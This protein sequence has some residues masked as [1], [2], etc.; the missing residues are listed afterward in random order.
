MIDIRVDFESTFHGRDI[1]GNL[2]WP[3]APARLFAALVAGCHGQLLGEAATRSMRQALCSLES[4]P[5]PTVFSAPVSLPRVIAHQAYGSSR[6][7]ALKAIN[8][9]EFKQTSG[10]P[11]FALPNPV[12]ATSL[13]YR[14]ECPTSLFGELD[15][16]AEGV[17][18]FGTS[19]DGCAIRV[20]ATPPHD[21]IPAH[22]QRWVPS[23]DPAGS[24]RSWFPGLLH[25][26]DV[27]F[28]GLSSGAGVDLPTPHGQR[29]RY[30]KS[31]RLDA[32]VLEWVPLTFETKSPPSEAIHE[33]MEAM[34]S[35][36]KGAI[37]PL[38]QG[39]SEYGRGQWLG[40]AVRDLDDVHRLLALPQY[41]LTYDA[42]DQRVW[43][44]PSRYEGP[45]QRWRTVT[46][47]YGPVH[48]EAATA[49]ANVIC[50]EQSARLL[51]LERTKLGTRGC[52]RSTMRAHPKGF[53]PYTVVVETPETLTRPDFP[54]TD[55]VWV[56]QATLSSC[57]ASREHGTA[58]TLPEAEK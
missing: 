47:W 10:K 12:R 40:V 39:D 22:W 58:L 9:T 55:T 46:P 51:Q 49:W 13:I 52:A 7:R 41:G 2:E 44:Q 25:A 5:A 38:V 27:R 48:Y 18:W 21:S 28:A 26:L 57:G 19:A 36:V 31:H 50:D 42:D 29:L 3:P 30:F 14:A 1:D 56:P 6:P 24:S 16:A 35:L 20:M 17:A 11:E 4:A 54:G 34:R 15:R 53:V 23:P 43:T 33:S 32:N 37:F 8:K 45:A